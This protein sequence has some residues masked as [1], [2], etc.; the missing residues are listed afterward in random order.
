MFENEAKGWYGSYSLAGRRSAENFNNIMHKNEI[1]R[2]DN[3]K[4]KIPDMFAPDELKPNHLEEKLDIFK[5]YSLNGESLKKQI[6]KNY[7]EEDQS[8]NHKLKKFNLFFH[9]RHCSLEN[10]KIGITTFEPG[11]TRYSPNYDYIWP[12]LITGIK[13]GD[14]MGRKKKKIPKDNRDFIINN[15][16]NYDK[17]IINS[18]FVKC[19]VNM[20][21]K[22]KKKIFLKKNLKAFNNLNKRLSKI[23]LDNASRN[24]LNTII[25]KRISKTTNNFLIPNISTEKT[26]MNTKDT[27]ISNDKTKSINNFI[28]MNF[29]FDMQ[30]SNT[31]E[32]KFNNLGKT[33]KNF[34]TDSKLLK[35]SDNNQKDI[36]LELTQED[37]NKSK[38]VSMKMNVHT[39]DFSKFTARERKIKRHQM[40]HVCYIC[41][42]YSFVQERSLTMAVYKK[43]KP[44]KSYK[45][46]PFEGMIMGLDYDPNKVIEKYNNHQS[47]KVPK[48]KNMTSRPNKK[49]SPL[50]SFLQR[51]H[52]RSASYLTTDKSLKLNSY[53][54]GKYIPAPNSFFPKK[55]Y[56]KIINVKMVNSNLFKE[57]SLDEDIQNKKNQVLEKLVL[58]KTNFEELKTEGALDKFDNFCYKTILR[59]K[60]KD[61]IKNVLMS[62]ESEEEKK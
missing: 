54:K 45:S 51:V 24:K 62:F 35:S 57:K 61:D 38:I 18:G 5:I 25:Q 49:G 48:F 22:K 12:K 36:N 9:N 10:K 59:K 28:G 20:N 34:F 3:K 33:H 11:C 7:N 30:K 32:Y 4:V 47:L 46:K 27:N 43:E 2:G 53:A 55:S 13:W 42:K 39:P 16:E 44:T 31:P 56:N 29:S 6:K 8:K 19:Y 60:A 26:K 23:V 41:P 37:E 40:E 17:Y 52:D 14:Q 58:E 50:P 15:L 1:L 21:S